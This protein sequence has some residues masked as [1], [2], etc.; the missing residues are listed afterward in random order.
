MTIPD[1]RDIDM[2]LPRQEYKYI[3]YICATMIC[4]FMLYFDGLV[5]LTAAGAVAGTLAGIN[6][7]KRSN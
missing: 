3:G 4:C 2:T 5:A 1:L 6:Y 7:T